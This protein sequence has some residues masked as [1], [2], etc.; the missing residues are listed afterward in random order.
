MMDRIIIKTE[1]NRII[2]NINPEYSLGEVMYAI[3]STIAS[4]NSILKDMENEDI[5]SRLEDVLDRESPEE[6]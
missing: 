6:K 3:M 5:L 4:K 1:L 2:D